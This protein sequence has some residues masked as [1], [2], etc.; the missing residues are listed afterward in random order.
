MLSRKY[1]LSRY[2]YVYANKAPGKALDPL[3]KEFAGFVLSK[4]GQEIVVKD[5]FFPL[6]SAVVAEELAKLAK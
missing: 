6:T 3:V 4:E 1:P 2:L 5:G